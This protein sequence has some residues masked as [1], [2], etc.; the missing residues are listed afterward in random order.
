MKLLLNYL[1]N[2]KGLIA[3]ALLL[4]S[5]SQIFSLLDPHITGKI[6]DNFI[7]KKDSLSRAEFIKGILFLVG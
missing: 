3:I 2:Y 1:K 4:A 7:E 6:V 5:T